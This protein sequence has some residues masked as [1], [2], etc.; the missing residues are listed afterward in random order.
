MSPLLYQ[1]SYTAR[2]MV[3]NLCRIQ[4]WFGECLARNIHGARRAGRAGWVGVEVLSFEFWVLSYPEVL[5]DTC[6]ALSENPKLR[7]QNSK[8]RTFQ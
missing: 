2:R 6:R 1:L 4:E 3:R 8:L 7:T 5:K